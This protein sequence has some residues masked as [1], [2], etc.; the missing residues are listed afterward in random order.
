MTQS[1]EE[2]KA[3]HFACYPS[4]SPERPILMP[5]TPLLGSPLGYST[6]RRPKTSQKLSAN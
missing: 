5:K 2:T 4:I 6:N 3:K 1:A